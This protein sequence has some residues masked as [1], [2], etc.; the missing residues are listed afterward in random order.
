MCF[1]GSDE[2]APAPAP[3]PETLKQAAPM[4]KT[5]DEAS[6]LS[7]GTKKYQTK[8][9]TSTSTNTGKDTGGSRSKTSTPGTTYGT[10]KYRKSRASG[11]STTPAPSGIAVNI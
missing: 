1:G 9:S 6:D 11:V 5:A 10:E 3:P 8:S 2:K 7:I 4:K